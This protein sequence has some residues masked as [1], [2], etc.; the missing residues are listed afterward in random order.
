LVVSSVK[1]RLALAVLPA[2]SR[3]VT[4]TVCLRS[5]VGGVSG[6]SADPTSAVWPRVI[7]A[8]AALTVSAASLVRLSL[9]ELP[10]SVASAIVGVAMG[11][12]GVTAGLA[13]GVL[14][15]WWRSV[16]NTVWLR[17]VVGAV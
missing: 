13:L 12:A 16:A 4:T 8:A 9:L 1:V 14:P 15:V 5:V 3:S 11:V 6:A 7:S 10:L 2:V 17:S